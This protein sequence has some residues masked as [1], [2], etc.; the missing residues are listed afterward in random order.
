VADQ[1]RRHGVEHAPQGEAARRRDRDHLLLEVGR[2]ALRQRSQGRALQRDALGV[3]GVAPADDGID[4][5]PVGVEVGEVA[6][7]VQ[8]QS[9]LQRLLEVAVRAL[10]RSVLVRDAGVVARRLH[11]VVAH[12]ALVAL[13]QVDLRV[14]V[15][16]T[17]RRRQAVAA[18]LLR[19]AAERPQRVL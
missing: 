3:V 13:G 5:R 18:M 11:G 10:D 2:A 4:E 8:E 7:A 17:E 9:V 6:A 19:H 15:E 14:G 12:E 16:V 1:P